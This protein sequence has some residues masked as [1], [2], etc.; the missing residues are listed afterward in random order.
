MRIEVTGKA[1]DVTD[2]IE[3]YANQKAEK[4]PRYYDGVQE[5]EV[6]LSKESHHGTFLAEFRV[7]CEKHDTFVATDQDKDIYKCIDAAS[8]KMTRQLTDFKEKLKDNKH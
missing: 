4:L 7:D 1:M 6:V 5:I 3:A 8:D 2:A